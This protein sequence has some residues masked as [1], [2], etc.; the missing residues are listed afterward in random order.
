MPLTKQKKKVPLPLKEC[1]KQQ[2][3]LVGMCLSIAVI[4]FGQHA[5]KKKMRML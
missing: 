3:A 5:K 2:D 4:V 1:P